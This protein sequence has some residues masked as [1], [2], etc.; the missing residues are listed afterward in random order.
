MIQLQIQGPLSPR[1]QTWNCSLVEAV[2]LGTGYC[3]GTGT[4]AGVIYVSRRGGD[5]KGGSYIVLVLLPTLS[6]LS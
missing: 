3:S 2:L 4:T 6:V 5:I 1:K